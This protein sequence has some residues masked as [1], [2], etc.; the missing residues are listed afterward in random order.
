MAVVR[1]VA[2]VH[3]GEV[4]LEENEQFKTIFTLKLPRYQRQAAPSE[5]ISTAVF[6]QRR[7]HREQPETEEA[8]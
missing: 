7:L 3:Q 8:A 5:S 4:Y 1:A 2:K 6:K